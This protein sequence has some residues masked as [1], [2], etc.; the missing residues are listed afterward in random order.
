MDGCAVGGG[1]AGIS[2][3][4]S[5]ASAHLAPCRHGDGQVADGMWE[6][7]KPTIA[8]THT[9]LDWTVGRSIAGHRRRRGVVE[10]AGWEYLVAVATSLR[11]TWLRANHRARQ[12][13]SG[14]F[15]RHWIC[16]SADIDTFPCRVP[17]SQGCRSCQNGELFNVLQRP[18]LEPAHVMPL[19]SP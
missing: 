6:G 4:F 14:P 9:N 16:A 13:S 12:R 5:Q 18:V 10:E 8:R 3:A 2:P 17:L 7:K 19:P 1:V 11:V 15:T